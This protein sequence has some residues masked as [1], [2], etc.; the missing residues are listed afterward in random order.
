MDERDVFLAKAGESLAGAEGELSNSRFNNCANRCYYACFQAAIGAL[1]QAGIRPSGAEW[2]H[3]F[4]QARFAG[5]LI[6]RR[7][8]YPAELRDVLSRLMFVRQLADYKY[9]YVSQTQ[10]TRAVRHARQFVST[11]QGQVGETP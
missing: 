1:I 9:E 10:A 6:A 2:S 8:V 5:D 4:V 11:I 3:E 7:K